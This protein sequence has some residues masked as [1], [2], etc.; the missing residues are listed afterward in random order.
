MGVCAITRPL[1][2]DMSLGVLEGLQQQYVA[3]Q[4]HQERNPTDRTSFLPELT[5]LPLPSSS[6]NTIQQLHHI[7]LPKQ[8]SC[9][10]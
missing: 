4:L 3:T 8:I 6:S 5:S 7:P 1:S 2:R 10:R 9:Q